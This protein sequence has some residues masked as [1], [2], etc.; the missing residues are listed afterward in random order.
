MSLM[1]QDAVEDEYIDENLI[2]N[3]DFSEIETYDP[4]LEGSYKEFFAIML[5]TTVKLEGEETLE[6]LR[7]RILVKGLHKSPTGIKV[8][9][10]CDSDLFFQYQMCCDEASFENIRYG[11]Q[12]TIDFDQFPEM[13][14]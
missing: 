1:L 3:I 5:P 4:N 7:A 14:K 6:M 2:A 11:S 10:D 9:L 13:I 12:L 8:T